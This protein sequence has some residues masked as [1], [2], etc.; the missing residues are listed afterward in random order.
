MA[1]MTAMPIYGKNHSK[2]SS[3]DIYVVR[4]VGIGAIPE[5]HLRK[6]GMTK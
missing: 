2:S 1:K 4:R 3:Q 6:V 5:L